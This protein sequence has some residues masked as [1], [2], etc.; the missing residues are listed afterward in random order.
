MS[1]S[2]CPL[3]RR[4][5]WRSFRNMRGA[6]FGPAAISGRHSRSMQSLTNTAKC[7]KRTPRSK[8][9]LR[10]GSQKDS[11]CRQA[12]ARFG[13]WCM[14]KPGL[15][16]L[17]RSRRGHC[18]GIEKENMKRLFRPFSQVDA[19]VTWPHRSGTGYQPASLPSDERRYHGGKRTADLLLLAQHLQRPLPQNPPARDPSGH[20]SQQCR[21]RHRSH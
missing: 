10:A 5:R 13:A 15:L 11:V 7:W 20:H 3:F 16:L 21:R 18:I 14:N 2:P 12:P 17:A 1:I 4:L 8:E 9:S 19:S 6:T